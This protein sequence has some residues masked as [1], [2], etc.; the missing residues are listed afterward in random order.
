MKNLKNLASVLFL[1]L[2][3]FVASCDKDDVD[4]TDYLSSFS[5]SPNKKDVNQNAAF[6]SATPTVKPKKAKVKFAIKG[7]KKGSDNFTNPSKGIKINA[8]TG[9]LS[10]ANDN[11]LEKAVYT[12][13]VEATD[14][15]K[16]TIKKTT[17]YKITIK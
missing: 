17:T 16:K 4:T 13:T 15:N 7:I 8:D 3:V 5:Y 2:L 1:G 11:T 12:V 9:K 10:L 14:Q 6:T